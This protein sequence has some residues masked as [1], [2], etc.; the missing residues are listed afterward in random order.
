MA[1]LYGSCEAS[2][3]MLFNWKAEVTRLMPNSVVEIDVE[4]FKHLMDNY[5]KKK[6][7]A[8]H[9]WPTARAYRKDVHGHHMAQVYCIPNV[10]PY[11]DR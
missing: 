3:G 11:L 5:V 9:M 10:K 1:E 4:C 8:E 7:G 6:K 2:F